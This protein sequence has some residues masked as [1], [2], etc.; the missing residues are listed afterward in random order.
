MEKKEYNAPTMK[1]REINAC[2]LMAGSTVNTGKSDDPATGDGRSKGNI[3]P[4]DED[5]APAGSSSVWED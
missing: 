2:G 4:T 1:V 3:F 5:N